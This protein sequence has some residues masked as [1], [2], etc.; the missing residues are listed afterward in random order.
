MWC[1]ASAHTPSKKSKSAMNQSFS[2]KSE[3]KLSFTPAA[4]GSEARCYVVVAY[5]S[6]A[7][8][9]RRTYDCASC[10]I[11]SCRRMCII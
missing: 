1:V 3:Y 10:R 4:H 9:V 2:A 6:S 8:I 11:C 5:A 7:A